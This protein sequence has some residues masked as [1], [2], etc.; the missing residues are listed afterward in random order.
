MTK[1][2]LKL[3]VNAPDEGK[4]E[5]SSFDGHESMEVDEQ[6]VKESDLDEDD[7]GVDDIE[8]Y[9]EEETGS[10]QT[11]DSVSEVTESDDEYVPVSKK[12]DQKPFNEKELS[13]FIRDT[14]VSKDVGEFMASVLLRRGLAQ[15]GT[16]SSIYRD[17]DKM[18]VYCVDVRGLLNEIKANVYQLNEWILFIDSSQRSLK[19]ILLHNG[20]KYARIPIAHSTKLKESYENM[21][22]VLEKINYAD[23]KWQVCGDLKIISIILGQQAGFTNFPYFLCL[24]DSRDRVKHYEQ[25]E[26][27]KRNALNPG[28]RNVIR[29]PLIERSKILLPPLHIKLGLMKQFTKA[30]DKEG[31]CFMYLRKQFEKLSDVKIKEGIFDGPQIRKMFKDKNFILYMNEK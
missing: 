1:S 15:P 25:K 14:G 29:E 20:N 5:E 26:W 16:K 9:E 31:Q 18:L 11:E 4:M 24:W 27:P 28:S 7:I 2:V 21:K 10:E 23:H 19:A 13:D 3:H 12:R 6:D 30:L 8:E 17:E 22:Y